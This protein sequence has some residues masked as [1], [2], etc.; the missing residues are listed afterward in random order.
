MFLWPD[1]PAAA[2]PPVLFGIQRL[3]GLKVR[4]NPTT[5]NSKEVMTKQRYIILKMVGGNTL[6]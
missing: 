2:T 1:D 3:M 6:I 4:R 5:K